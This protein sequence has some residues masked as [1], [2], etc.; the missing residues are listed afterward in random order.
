MIF[1][2]PVQYAIW[3]VST[4][5]LLAVAV[6]MRRNGSHRAYPVFFVYVLFVAAHGAFLLI[7]KEFP[8][9]YFYGY[10]AG[11]LV[12]VALSFSVLFE[13][14]KAVQSLPSFTLDRTRFVQLCVACCVIAILVVSQ[15]TVQETSTIMRAR[16]LIEEALRVVQLGV[17]CIFVLA[18]KFFGLYWKRFEFGIVAGYGLYAAV[19]LCALLIRA[20]W[21]EAALEHFVLI[22]SLSFFAACLIWVTY[23]ARRE[24]AANAADLPLSE[25][26]ESLEFAERRL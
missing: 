1:S 13:A 10:Y 19:E 6:F 2:A 9:L 17:L 15:T 24:Q 8:L 20:L 5:I 12:S 16:V 14:S 4:V 7:I 11:A 21:G 25:F 3:I 26:Q 18:T 22:K 23:A